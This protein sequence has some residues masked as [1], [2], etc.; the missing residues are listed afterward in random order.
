MSPDAFAPPRDDAAQ[1]PGRHER[2]HAQPL[3]PG[4]AADEPEVAFHFQC[5][6]GSVW[7]VEP[8]RPP[9]G[10]GTWAWPMMCVR[11]I[12]I[13]ERRAIQAASLA[14]AWYCASVNPTRP[15][16]EA[17]VLDPDRLLVRGPVAGVPGDVGEVDELDDP[18]VARDDEVRGSVCARVPQPA[19]RPPELALGDVDDDLV[20]RLHAAVRLREVALA[21]QPD[22]RRT[23][24]DRGVRDGDDEPEAATAA[25]RTTTLRRPIAAPSLAPARPRLTPHLHC[26][27]TLD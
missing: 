14:D 11:S 12:G 15:V 27:Y 25:A 4:V 21:P 9:P 24:A 10:A 6:P 2:A 8:P 26:S 16:G 18:A 20:D 17:L 1:R 13:S 5:G 22:D 23:C 7:W 19:H 3:D